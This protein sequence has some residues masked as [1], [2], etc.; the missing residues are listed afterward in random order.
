MQLEQIDHIFENRYPKGFG[1][2]TDGVRE[3]IQMTKNNKHSSDEEKGPANNNEEKSAGED[4]SSEMNLRKTHSVIEDG[5]EVEQA[6][7]ASIS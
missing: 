7:R 4:N 2:F 6:E 3:S 5:K 1:H